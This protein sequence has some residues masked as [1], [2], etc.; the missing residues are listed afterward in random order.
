MAKKRPARKRVATKPVPKRL[1]K[2]KVSM[3]L[4][5]VRTAAPSE[6]D[7]YLDFGRRVQ[8]DVVKLSIAGLPKE[9]SKGRPI[10]WINNF[11]VRSKGKFVKR[12]KYTLYL[13]MPRKKKFVYYDGQRL[14]TNKKPR[15]L[16]GQERKRFPRD[17]VKVDFSIG[18]PAIGTT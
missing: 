7:V 1:V 18:D 4:F 14:R 5:I 11:G 10:T 13:R 6:E 3:G 15:V 9:L 12:A 16:S 2:G 8:F 17:W